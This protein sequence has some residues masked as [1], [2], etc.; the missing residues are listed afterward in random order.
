MTLRPKLRFA[1]HAP[2]LRSVRSPPS[3]RELEELLPR[4]TAPPRRGVT[5]VEGDQVG[6]RPQIG[7][8]EALEVLGHVH[9]DL[10][11]HHEELVVERH[12]AVRPGVVG[13]A[14]G[15]LVDHAPAARISSSAVDHGEQIVVTRP[16]AVG[17][18]PVVGEAHALERAC[19]EK[20]L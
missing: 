2:R 3:P 19:V 11:Q 10:E 12:T 17:V 5:A 6:E 15:D 14:R 20:A 8:A 13:S 7:L 9:L 18:A 4:R 1:P 16:V